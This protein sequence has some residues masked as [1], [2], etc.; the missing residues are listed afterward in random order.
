M[1][2]AVVSR[3]HAI[4]YFNLYRNTTCCMLFRLCQLVMQI[5]GETWTLNL[6][7][8]APW[9]S[10]TPCISSSL[11]SGKALVCVYVHASM[12]IMATPVAC[13][14]L[15]RG[16][17]DRWRIATVPTERYDDDDNDNRVNY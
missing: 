4:R 17:L 11:L 3:I 6:Q 8:E 2:S 9:P 12:Q 10:T 15:Q 1:H 7:L 16:N 14:T 5:I 13:D